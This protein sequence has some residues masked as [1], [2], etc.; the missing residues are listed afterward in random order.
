MGALSVSGP[1]SRQRSP[2]RLFFTWTTPHRRDRQADGRTEGT[3]N[4]ERERERERETLRN[5]TEEGGNKVP[6][7]LGRRG[8]TD[9]VGVSE[10][11]ESRCEPVTL[12]VVL[13]KHR[14]GRRASIF[15]APLFASVSVFLN[16]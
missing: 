5:K 4:E 1:W 15:L 7:S 2:R 12:Q 11:S 13:I 9:V 6:T 14:G 10:G 3:K 8:G 16:K